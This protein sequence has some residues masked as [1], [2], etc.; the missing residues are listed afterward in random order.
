MKRLFFAAAL[1]LAT[2]TALAQSPPDP[3]FGNVTLPGPFISNDGGTPATGVAQPTGGAGLS[4]WLSGI[5]KALTGDATA[6][7]A[8][9]ST[10]NQLT[11]TC[12]ASC[13]GVAL[14]TVDTTGFQSIHVQ[15]IASGSGTLVAESSDDLVCATATNW[16]QVAG[17][18]E[19]ANQPQSGN[20]PTY[21]LGGFNGSWFFPTRAHCFRVAFQSYTGG[22]FTVEAYLRTAPFQPLLGSGLALLQPS[23]GLSDALYATSSGSAVPN[24][25]VYGGTHNLYGGYAVNLT[26]TAG[27][28]AVINAATAPS[29][30]SA[31]APLDCIPLPPNGVA[32]VPTRLIPRYFSTNIVFLLT[33]AS[34]CF[35]YT[36]GT[37]TG[38]ISVDSK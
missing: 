4:G 13:S 32:T 28:L 23:G 26:S 10:S 11:G 38:F 31:I 2:A 8:N 15:E 7:V 34:N 12:S 16:Q 19:A 30:G 35:T 17:W 25:V 33:S 22:T 14:L 27:F 36:S 24:L 1:A 20:A 6:P 9:S 5:Y 29:S 3:T 21:L 37:I 18:Y